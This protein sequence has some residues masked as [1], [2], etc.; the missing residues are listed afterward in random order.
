MLAELP[1]PLTKVAAVAVS[2]TAGCGNGA[3]SAEHPSPLQREDSGSSMGGTPL[4]PVAQRRGS[5]GVN[6][7]A[8]SSLRSYRRTPLRLGQEKMVVLVLRTSLGVK[9]SPMELGS[10]SS[11]L[12][13]SP[14]LCLCSPEAEKR[15]SPLPS[16]ACQCFDEKEERKV[17]E[18]IHATTMSLP[19]SR[20]CRRDA[21]AARS[22]PGKESVALLSRETSERR[23][24]RSLSSLPGFPIAAGSSSLCR[25]KQGREQLVDEEEHPPLCQ[26]PSNL[27]LPLLSRVL[28]GGV[29]SLAAVDEG[30]GK[31]VG[32]SCRRWN[33]LWLLLLEPLVEGE[34]RDRDGRGGMCMD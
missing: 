13:P 6:N 29:N 17:E 10:S 19:L 4:L 14:L 22:S 28:A 5:V 21:M 9:S 32:S 31:E 26:A 3:A 20:R 7:S 12:R 16:Q 23:E 2:P 11:P 25:E 34:K 27:P 33:S 30:D 18:S 15:A 24:N 8:M 1:S